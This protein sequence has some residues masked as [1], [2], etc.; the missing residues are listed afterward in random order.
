MR[1]ALTI[2]TRNRCFC[3]E[4]VVPRLK[5]V[6]WTDKD[7]KKSSI[8]RSFDGRENFRQTYRLSDAKRGNSRLNEGIGDIEVIASV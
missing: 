6:N 7:E 3:Q 5:T 4:N 1:N 2:I 8:G